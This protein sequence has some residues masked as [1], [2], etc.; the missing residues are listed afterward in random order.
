MKSLISILTCVLVVALAASWAQ[1]PPGNEAGV[2]MGHLHLNVRDIAANKTFFVV[3]GGSPVKVEP[4]E[5][6]KFPG[7]LVYLNLPPGAQPATGGIIGTVVNH[8]GF[9]VRNLQESL[10]KWKA[11]GLK[12]EV[13]PNPGQAFAYTPDNIRFEI[14]EDKS[15]TVPI[16][17][18][19]IHFFVP[20]AD[21]PKIQ[22]WYAKMFGTKPGMRLQNQAA[23][24]PGVNLTFSKTP[25]PTAGTKGHLLD[26]IGFEIK[27]LEAFCKKLE[28]TGMKFDRPYI[29]TATGLGLAFLTDPWGTYIELNE[30]LDRY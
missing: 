30:G 20:E 6:V 24:L 12:L 16:A 1:I 9:R 23:D 21:V 2:A 14:L 3:L 17:M 7:V 28:E 5:I 8:F 13:G 11:A 27:N 26:H 10:T 29:K 15:L 22:A 18:H 4:F 25:D 19:H